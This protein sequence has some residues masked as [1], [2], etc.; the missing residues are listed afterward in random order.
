MGL[1]RL[2]TPGSKGGADISAL[3]PSQS[4]APLGCESLKP[5][6]QLPRL[7]STSMQDGRAMAALS[8]ACGG[9]A[10]VQ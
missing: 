9:N 4:T 8:P 1:R 10:G 6:L 7:T 5:L 2:G 3:V